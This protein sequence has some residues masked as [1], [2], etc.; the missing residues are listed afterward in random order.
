VG[1][2]Q[3]RVLVLG[4]NRATNWDSRHHGFVCRDRF[5]GVAIRRL[6]SATDG[7]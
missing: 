1:F 2:W 5:I 7:R 3:H 6:S 4:D